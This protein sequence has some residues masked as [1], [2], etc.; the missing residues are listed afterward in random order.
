MATTKYKG[1]CIDAQGKYYYQTELG[2]DRVT[3]KRIRKKGRKDQNGK[4]FSSAH[5][6]FK[7]LTRIR[8]EYFKAKGYANYNITYGQ[9]MDN[10]YI[11]AYQTDVEEST[12]LSRKGVLE[13]IRDRF[14]NV[15]LRSLTFEQVQNYRTWLLSKRGA[16]YSQSY[17]G[18]IFGMFRK[19]L[20]MAVDMQYLET[21]I[22]KKVKAI[23]KSKAIVPY[24]T[25][26]DFEKVIATICLDDFYEHLNFV[27]LW[28]Y[29][30]T[31]VRVNEGTALWWDDVDFMKKRLRVHHMLIMKNKHDWQRNDYTKTADGK[32][33]IAL[34]DD[35]LEILRVWKER[36]S[37]I[38]IDNFVF[39][40]DG[41]PMLKST[42][43]KI[44]ARYA[45]LAGVRRIQAKGLRHSHASYLI[46]EFNVSV[47]I[48]SKRMGHSSPEITLKH[49]SHL[50]SGADAQIAE[51]MTGN[52]SIKTAKEKGFKFT[53]N[54]A[55]KA[56][57]FPTTPPTKAVQH[58]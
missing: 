15:P 10:V 13:R 16:G 7:E 42:I 19:S 2:T 35:T 23:P 21:N 55:I 18:L 44:I 46:N 54:Q 31:G 57:A 52:I 47:L 3:G 30:M 49:Y 25:K 51:E 40:Y 39:S 6:A 26:R 33:T 14:V 41:T 4:P 1:V 38:G 12:F 34:D 22:S 56:I 9:F 29:Y 36:Q 28:V 58:A 17:A 43:S 8:N 11:P 5:E 45:K 37:Q 20:D 24:W 27:M 50:W 48:L 32:R 53:G